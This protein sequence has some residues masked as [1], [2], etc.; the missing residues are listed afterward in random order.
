MQNNTS[1]ITGVLHQQQSQQ[2]YRLRRYFPDACLADMIEQFWL[3]DWNLA[4]SKTHTQQNLPDPNFHL[5]INDEG[6]R[7]ISPVSKVYAYEMKGEG[8]IIGVKF[9]I[10]ALDELLDL[11]LASYVD[12]VIDASKVFDADVVAELSKLLNVNDDSA[13]CQT[14]QASLKP[15]ATPVSEAQSVVRHLVRLM[16]E[17]SSL[18]K[19]T[20][21]AEHS[22]HS[23]RML[24]RYFRTYVGLSPKW[25]IRK[26]RLHQALEQLDSGHADILDIVAQLEYTDQSHLIRD[27]KD[28]VGVTPRGYELGSLKA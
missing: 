17:D 21:L 15:F 8:K 2:H 18:C 22:G 13:I 26:Y 14:L 6:A 16:K 3:V 28:V 9:E 27:F 24:Q 1:K 19:V 11:P 25:L 23:P 7:I 20:E 12:K 5:V 10:G 4:E